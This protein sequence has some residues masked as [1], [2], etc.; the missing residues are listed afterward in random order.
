MQGQDD[1]VTIKLISEEMKDSDVFIST[2]YDTN[3][4][5]AALKSQE[6]SQK[7]SGPEKCYMCS[8]TVYPTER[9]APNN[10]VKR[11]KFFEF[12]KKI[13]HLKKNF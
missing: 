3:E 4:I 5:K 9:L 11:K 8:K 6:I 10:K 7:S 12:F 2:E 1:H 13:L